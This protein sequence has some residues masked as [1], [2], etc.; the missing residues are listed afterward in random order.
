MKTYLTDD[1]VRVKLY[2]GKFEEVILNYVPMACY[3]ADKYFR[4]STTHEQKDIRS[5]A[6]LALIESMPKLVAHPNPR[7]FLTLKI[8]GAVVNFVTRDHTIVPDQK[9]VY[10]LAKW[11]YLEDVDAS[12]NEENLSIPKELWAP[13]DYQHKDVTQKIFDSKY[14]SDLEKEIIGYRIDGYIIEEISKKCKL[15]TAYVQRV[16]I[17]VQSR[18][19]KILKDQY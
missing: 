7:G 5:V 15:S 9:D 17:G 6:L 1:E 19:E 13:F 11:V 8:R 12:G 3:F 10:H 18:V 14:L 16:I 4:R 2:E